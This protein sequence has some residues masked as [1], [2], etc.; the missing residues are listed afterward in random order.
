MSS[1][2][3]QVGPVY[4]DTHLALSQIGDEEA[5]HS[6]LLMLQESLARDIPLIAQ[7]FRDGDLV[8]ANRVLHAL[9]GFVPIFCNEHLC[10]HV[11]RVEG[12]SKDRHSI[13][14]GPAYGVLMPEL[15]QLL[16]EVSAHLQA[17]AA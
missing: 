12:L 13:S 8:A 7:L 16:S 10:E 2:E 17:S 9:K 11:V 5:M 15:E 4:L 1:P 6:M 14:A 3:P